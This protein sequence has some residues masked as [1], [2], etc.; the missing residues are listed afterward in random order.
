MRLIKLSDHPSRMLRDIHKQRLADERRA[1][2]EFAGGQA[3]HQSSLDRARAERDE[4]FARHRWWTWI[5]AVFAVWTRQ[6]R[7]PRSPAVVSATTDREES[8][9]AGI[10][11]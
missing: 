9:A 8:I 6:R 1:Q 10:V 5:R 4:A 2:A 7:S 11:G 3:G